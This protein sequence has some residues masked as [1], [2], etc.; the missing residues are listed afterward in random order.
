MQFASYAVLLA[1]LC[2]AALSSDSFDR[3]TQPSKGEVLQAGTTYNIKWHSTSSDNV[4]LM[5][6]SNK[7]SEDSSDSLN[8]IAAIIDGTVGHHS[9]NVTEG[10]SNNE[11]FYI[12]IGS[13]A[14]VS[15]FSY[16]PGFKIHSNISSVTA[17]PSATVTVYPSATG[18]T[19]ASANVTE[20][21]STSTSTAGGFAT[22]APAPL[23]FI[24]AAAIGMLVF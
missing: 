9:W 4:N 24:G 11:T 23:A 1:S 17:T 7:K 2:C 12:K 6:M 3:I 18:S 15:N 13:V 8:V 21:P 19:T 20:S 10:L 16:S 14:D 22:S 5:L